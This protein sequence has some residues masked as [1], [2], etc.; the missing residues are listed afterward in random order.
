MARKGSKRDSRRSRTTEQIFRYWVELHDIHS[1]AVRS[2][3]LSTIA[4]IYIPRKRNEAQRPREEILQLHDDS[5]IIEARNLEDLA[6]QLRRE[7]P[8]EEYK[9]T[10]HRERDHEAEER[11]AEAMNGLI[12][13][14]AKAAVE[15]LLRGGKPLDC[16]HTAGA[17]GSIPVPPTK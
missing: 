1:G 15:Q 12:E 13:I 8:D 7:Y 6:A 9:R 14:L 10:L 3:P 4:K 2:L 5:V 17:T 11:R 16:L